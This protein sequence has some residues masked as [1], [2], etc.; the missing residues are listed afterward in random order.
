M[1]CVSRALGDTGEPIDCWRMEH[2]DVRAAVRFLTQTIRRHGMPEMMTGDGRKPKAVAIG[3]GHAAHSTAIVMRQGNDFNNLV[4]PDHRRV[5]RVTRAMPGFTS[6]PAP[7]DP[8]RCPTPAR[9]AERPLEG[10]VEP[11]SSPATSST[12]RQQAGRPRCR[13]GV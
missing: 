3:S 2:R 13:A 1:G 11:R 12:A 8:R 7:A 4:A 9:A 5:T 6:V 10:G